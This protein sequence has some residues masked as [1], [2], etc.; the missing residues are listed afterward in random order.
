MY[1]KLKKRLD[2]FLFYGLPGYDVAVMRDGELVCRI[3]EGY[4]DLAKTKPLD[5]TEH[6]NLYSCSKLITVTAALLLLERGIIRLDDPVSDYRDA[7]VEYVKEKDIRF[8]VDL[9]QMACEREILINFGT[10]NGKNL[11]DPALLA[12]F[13]RAFRCHG[14]D[15]ILLD[16][17][18][19]GSYPY[20]VS[21]TVSRACGI[22]ALQIE[23]NS[24]LVHPGWEG[25][26]PAAVYA[27]LA[28]SCLT[29]QETLNGR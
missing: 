6:Y 16:T 11:S 18:F 24:R 25:Y 9:H 20:T 12:V 14:M 29:L 10:G 27:A 15:N 22:P 3:T 13:D 26:D 2:G 21:S 7:L 8:V 19:S 1:S 17:L 23:I 4:R 5:G 28:E